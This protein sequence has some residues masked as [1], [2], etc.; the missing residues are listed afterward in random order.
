MPRVRFT[1]RTMM[2]AVAIV[3]VLLLCSYDWPRR[4]RC[5]EI[6]SRHASLSVEYRRNA[7]GARSM[8]RAAAWHDHMRRIFEDAADRPWEPIP[9]SSPFPPRA[10]EP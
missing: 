2:I 9:V 4:E 3:A 1:V 7:K 5:Y 6:A 10:L 8:L